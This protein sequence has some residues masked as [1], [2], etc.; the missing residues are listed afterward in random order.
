MMA[1]S[2]PATNESEKWVAVGFGSIFPGMN[3]SDIVLGYIT[4]TGTQCV[5]SMTAVNFVGA[6]IDT[7]TVALQNTAVSYINGWLTVEFS[8]KLSDGHNPIPLNPP[9]EPGYSV[10]WAIGDN[11]L[12]QCSGKPK[13]HSHNR[14]YRVI[15]VMYPDTVFD[16]YRLC[17]N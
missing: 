11:T 5:R 8:R 15:N 6:P 3:T 16:N 9:A 14:G 10:I 1:I 2:I 13:Y 17:T 4:P 12:T 7:D